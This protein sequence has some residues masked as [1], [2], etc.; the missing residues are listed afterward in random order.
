M[1][2]ATFGPLD[3]ELIRILLERLFPG[4]TGKS[5]AKPFE[6]YE[7]KFRICYVTRLSDHPGLCHEDIIAIKAFIFC[8]SSA[9]GI[10]PRRVRVRCPR[11]SG[12]AVAGFWS[13]FQHFGQIA[14]F[15]PALASPGLLQ[16]SQ[17]IWSVR[18]I[19]TKQ[20]HSLP[21]PIAF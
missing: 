2:P 9:S 13:S 11:M 5:R 16:Y 3:L 21:N 10:L 14:T 15:K 18:Y 6:T 4:E 1:S 7:P 19:L 20:F 17:F 8:L 12:R